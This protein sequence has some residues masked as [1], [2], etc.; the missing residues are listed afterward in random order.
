MAF[1]DHDGVPVYYDARG[2]VA[3]PALVL[4]HG[5][6]SSSAHWKV[7]GYASAFERTHRVVLVDAR[8]HGKSGKPHAREAYALG[9]RLGDVHAVLEAAGIRQA[10]FCGFSMGGWMALGMAL[11]APERVASLTLVGAHPYA[12][13]FDAFAG[14]DG[15][16]GDVFLAA[17]ERFLGEPL[18][19]EARRMLLLNDLR[20]L[21]AAAIDRD[22]MEAGFLRLP[23]PVQVCVGEHDQRHVPAHRAAQ[24]KGARFVAIPGVRHADTL[25]ATG[26]LIPA[27][28]QFIAGAEQGV[29]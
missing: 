1:A 22:S 12:E 17:F 26:T 9:L 25:N 14:V 19:P 29:L 18:G 2:D 6:G 24:A 13:R 28:K 15:S 16:D 5:F 21:C 3:A 8:G 27:I 11:Q 4:L 20:A 10:H 23:M 7:L